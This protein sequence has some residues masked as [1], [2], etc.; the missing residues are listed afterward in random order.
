MDFLSAI[1]QGNLTALRLTPKS[2]LHNHCLLGGKRAYIEHYYGKKLAPFY[3]TAVGIHD[4]NRWIRDVYKPFLSLPGAFERAVEAAFIQAKQDGITVLE[5]SIDV[6][7]GKMFNV[8]DERVVKTLDR[9]HKTLAPEL[10]FRPEMGFPRTVSPEILRSRFETLMDFHY[11]R[12]VDLYDDE[13]A[14]PIHCFKEIYQVARK[15]GIKC[16]AHVGEFG[17]ADS[18]KEAVEVLQ[19]DAVQHGIGVADSHAVMKWMADLKIPLNICPTSNIRLKRIRS[20]KT[21][22]IRILFDQGV[23]VTVNTDDALIFNTSVS[24]EFKKLFKAG[25]FNAAELD[26][27]RVYGLDAI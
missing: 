22:P 2:D 25:L 7:F 11:F 20:L 5:M 1:S 8:S 21:H 15:M 6:M 17:D 16:K 27:I 3:A 23:I 18:V 24:G 12:S 10:D 13:F 26:Q 9:C 14:Q 19:L 4:M